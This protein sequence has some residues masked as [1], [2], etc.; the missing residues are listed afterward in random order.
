MVEKLIHAAG[1]IPS[2]GNSHSCR[3]T[4]IPTP[5]E[6][7]VLAAYNM[8]LMSQTPGLGSCFVSLAQ[9]AI[10]SSRTCKQIL[11]LSSEDH[12]HAVLAI[13][14][15]DVQFHRVIPKETKK[16]EQFGVFEREEK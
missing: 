3:F 13:G 11:N 1:Y 15:P 2:G 9:N 12:V 7:S 16:V 5:V 10:N 6:D 4:L 8:V 14:H